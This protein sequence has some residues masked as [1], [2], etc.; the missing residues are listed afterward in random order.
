M[1][2]N[3][4]QNACELWHAEATV[5]ELKLRQL[6]VAIF[7]KALATVIVAFGILM[8]NVSGFLLMTWY[9]DEAQAAGL[10]GLFDFALAAAL[11]AYANKRTSRQ[12]AVALR[13]RGEAF[14]GLSEDYHKIENQISGLTAEL[15]SVRAFVSEVLKKPIR[16]AVSYLID[17]IFSILPKRPES[18]RQTPQPTMSP[19]K[20]PRR[21]RKS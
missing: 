2:E 13:S 15:V 9:F 12:I 8:L 18:Q 17:L 11:I 5:V 16:E 4:V 20:P 14:K 7:L 1:I 21:N 19:S 3:I 6:I 10:V